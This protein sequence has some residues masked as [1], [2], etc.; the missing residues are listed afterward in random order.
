MRDQFTLVI[1]NLQVCFY[2]Q[3]NAQFASYRRIMLGSTP[4]TH[5]RR[6]ST[7]SHSSEIMFAY[8][9]FKC[10]HEISDPLHNVLSHTPST[11]LTCDV[12]Y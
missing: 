8:Y 1:K 5:R 10:D 6:P 9:V 7:T 2:L 11:P 4:T 3:Q 12:V